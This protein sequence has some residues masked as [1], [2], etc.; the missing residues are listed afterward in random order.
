MRPHS[1]RISPEQRLREIAAILACGLRR[2]R[3]SHDASPQSATTSAERI[4]DD[5]FANCLEV[6]QDLR[7]SV[8]HNG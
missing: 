8:L 2:L 4:S 3:T 6:P 1:D 5:S 7:L